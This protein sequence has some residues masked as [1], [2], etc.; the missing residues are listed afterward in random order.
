MSYGPYISRLT[1]PGGATYDI[2]DAEARELINQIAAGGLSFKISSTAATTPVGVSWEKDGVIIVG[3]LVAGDGTTPAG[4][5]NTRPYIYLVPHVQTQG[6]VDYYFEYVTVNEG[7]DVAP[8]YVWEKLGS[9]DPQFDELGDLA[10]KDTAT[11]SVSFTT[12]DSGSFTNGT[13]TASATYTPAGSVSVTLSQV[14]T[15][16]SVVYGD[17]TPEGTISKPDIT[18]TPTTSSFS[19]MS[20]AGTVT[21][22]TSAAFQ[23]GTDNW[24]APSWTATVSSSTETLVF[25]WNSGAFQQGSDSFTANQPTAV[26]LPTFQNATVMTGASAA[27]NS[28]PTFTG[29]TYASAIVTSVSYNQASIQGTE[30]TGSQATIQTTGTASGDVTLTKTEKT[31]TVTV[32]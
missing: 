26:T 3:T 28:A 17:Y 25:S 9:T 30:F 2:K 20:T 31:Q 16:A 21:G 24:T 13:V 8:V 32:S 10:Y 23:Q 7:T 6:D 29:S 19:V 27:L 1:L 5:Q 15:G 12:A 22:G 14:S 4:S 11:G 18:V